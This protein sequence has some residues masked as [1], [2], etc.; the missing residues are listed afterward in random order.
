MDKTEDKEIRKI[1]SK[2]NGNKNKIK[3]KALC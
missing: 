2:K 1:K 3:T